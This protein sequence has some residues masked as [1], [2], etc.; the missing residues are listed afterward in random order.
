MFRSVTLIVWVFTN[1]IFFYF[2]GKAQRN[3]EI[4]EYLIM[5]IAYGGFIL[6]AIRLIGS[7][8]FV[9]RDIFRKSYKA[10]YHKRDANE[11]DYRYISL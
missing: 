7:M 8:V 4:G 2:L 5:T 9:I 1:T 3:T 6:F 10:D 11:I